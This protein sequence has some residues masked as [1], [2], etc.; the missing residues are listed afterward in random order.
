[1]SCSTVMFSLFLISPCTQGG[2]ADVNE[3]VEAAVSNPQQ[4]TETIAKEA[5]R[6][7]A[8]VLY[9]GPT[10]SDPEIK[11]VPTISNKS[12]PQHDADG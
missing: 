5:N 6:K 2:S 4:P 11:A 8:Q 7:P 10:L 9:S 12:N 3:A 1:M